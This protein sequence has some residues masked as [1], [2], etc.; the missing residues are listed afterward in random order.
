MKLQY[1]LWKQLPLPYI[2]LKTTLN[3]ILKFIV[4]KAG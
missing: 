2:M 4:T 3:E 1:K